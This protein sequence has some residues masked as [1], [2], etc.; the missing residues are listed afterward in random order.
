MR[1]KRSPFQYGRGKCIF[2]E[3]QPPDV[4][5]TREHIFGEWL[6]ANFRRDANTTHTY[7]TIKWPTPL[8]NVHDGVVITKKQPGHS[9]TRKVRAVCEQC[10]TTWM[11]NQIEGLVKPILV[12]MM[13]STPMNIDI[14]KQRILSLWATKIAMVG[15]YI[16]SNHSVVFQKDR[17][18]V[19]NNLTLPPG[20]HVWVASYNGK[21][22]RELSLFQHQGSLELPTVDNSAPAPHNLELTTIGIGN[23]LFLIINSSWERLWGILENIVGNEGAG[24][25]RLWPTLNDK[26]SWPSWTILGGGEVFHYLP[27]ARLRATHLVLGI[28]GMSIHH[29]PIASNDSQLG[30]LFE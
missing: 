28:Q 17:T 18:Y 7:G 29:R 3:R 4:K 1:R 2:C 12:P 26:I 15:D 13:T 20:W 11:S 27:C 24:F 6:R 14:E 10:N 16:D 19:M 25:Y 9:G 23:L 21:I 22:Y 8:A 5:I 30:I